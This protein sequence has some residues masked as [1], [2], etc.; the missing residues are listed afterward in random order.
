MHRAR[1]VHAAIESLQGQV[2]KLA[3]VRRD[4]LNELVDQGL[5]VTKISEGVGISRSRVSQLRSA[6]VK[7][8]RLFFGSG[9]VTVAIGSKPEL[10]RKDSAQKSMVSQEAFK[11]YELIAD[12]T[13]SL[14]LDAVQEI[15]PPSGMI[16]LNRE[17][18]VVLC[19]VRLL[20]FLSQVMAA[21]SHLDFVEDEDGWFLRDHST[22]TDYRSPRDSGERKDIGYVGR[23]PGPGGRNTFLYAAGIHAEGTLGAARWLADNA[24]DLYKQ[25]KLQRFSTLVEADF[26]DSGNVT[27][28]QQLTALYREAKS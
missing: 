20:P 24:S 11:A 5:T 9:R 7:P 19:S 1:E 10:G 27:S 21:D 3:A 8:E 14:G 28:T 22:S 2:N 12:T 18:L 6:G 15:V 16:D 25:L 13:R 26:D 17:N 23:L 4:A